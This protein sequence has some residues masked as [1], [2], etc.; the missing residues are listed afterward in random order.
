MTS[1][2]LHFASCT[3]KNDSTIFVITKEN[4]PSIYIKTTNWKF[5]LHTMDSI[6][7]VTVLAMCID[8]NTELDL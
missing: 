4:S 6:Y 1:C 5:C 2:G 8:N 3:E 7:Y